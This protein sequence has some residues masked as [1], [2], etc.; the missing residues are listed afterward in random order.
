MAAVAS[1]SSATPRGR[2]PIGARR[3]SWSTLPGLPRSASANRR[4]AAGAIV[5]DQAPARVARAS[6][7]WVEGDHDARLLERVWGDDLRELAIVVEPLGGIDDLAAAVARFGPG[8][9]RSLAVLVDHLVDGSKESRI[10]ATVSGPHVMVVGHPFVDIWQ[11]VRPASLGIESWP[12]VPRGEDWKTGVCRRLGWSRPG[13]RVAAGAR[14]GRFL[15]RPRLDPRRS[16]RA[17]ARRRS[18][19]PHEHTRR[20]SES[21]LEA[22]LR[23]LGVGRVYGRPLAGLDHVARRGSRRR[24]AA[25]RRRRPD[26]PRRRE[27]AAR[28]RA[29]W[30]DRSCTCRPAPA[31]RRRC[32]RCPPLDEVLAALADSPGLDVPGDDR[33]AP[34]PRPRRSGP[35]RAVGRGGTVADSR[36]HAG[37]LARRPRHRGRRRA[38]HRANERRRLGPFVLP[39][40]RGGSRGDVGGSRRRTSGQ[41]VQLRCRRAS[42]PAT[43]S[44]PASPR[45]TSWWPAA[46]TPT[47]S[48]SPI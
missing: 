42:R 25:G 13:G 44:W 19:T 23:Q 28:R 45:P 38:G 5:S 10:A 39:V 36:A 12:D 1:T 33:A 47:S 48:G 34:R 3:S 31:E 29:G 11:C 16:G 2:S 8:P 46:S 17:G 6:R 30:T 37:P 4:S 9:G 32:R 7:L 15:R 43:W 22:R 27:R 26:R 24:G 21:V 40:H 18:P 35:I 41:P 20:R 14:G